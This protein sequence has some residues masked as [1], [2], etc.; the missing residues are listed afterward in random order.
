M[1]RGRHWFKERQE[2]RVRGLAVSL[3]RLS[4]SFTLCAFHG[5]SATTRIGAGGLEYSR[6][7][8]PN[9]GSKLPLSEFGLRLASLE[10]Q[11]NQRVFV[12]AAVETSA[13]TPDE[14]T[15]L[16]AHKPA[17]AQVTVRG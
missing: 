3:L 10:V 6:K 4:A 15:E 7:V 8:V 13:G 17:A 2:D 11:E 16:I 1:V 14:F 9:L 5:R 12:R